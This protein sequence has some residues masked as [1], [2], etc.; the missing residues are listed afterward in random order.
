[1]KKRMFLSF[2]LLSLPLFAEVGYVEPWGKDGVFPLPP[3]KEK[4]QLLLL[5]PMARVA[6]SVILFHH[7]FITQIDGPRSHFRPSSSNY[8]LE[9]IRKHGFAKGYILGCDRLLRE[10]QDPWR[11]R[12]KLI[13]GCLHKWN[14]PPE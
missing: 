8:M 11:Y 4:K 14:P 6:E 10:N 13:D 5:S 9:A 2:F 3:K 12:L 7:K 1:M